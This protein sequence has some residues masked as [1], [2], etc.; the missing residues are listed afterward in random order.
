MQIRFDEVILQPKK[1]A[2]YGVGLAERRAKRVEH[3][4]NGRKK[5]VVW[6]PRLKGC[7]ML[8]NVDGNMFGNL[9]STRD[10]GIRGPPL[11]KAVLKNHKERCFRWVEI[12]NNS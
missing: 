10:V 7:P 3:I 2:F 12:S 4:P 5:T 9:S 1:P 6:P 8:S 11:L